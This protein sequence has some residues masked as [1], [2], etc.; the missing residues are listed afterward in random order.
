MVAVNTIRQAV[1]M[2]RKMGI[3]LETE[4]TETEADRRIVIKFPKEE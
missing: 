3:Q 1:E 4:E 2:C